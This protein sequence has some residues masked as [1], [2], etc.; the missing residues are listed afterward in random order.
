MCF[1]FFKAMGHEVGD[2]LCEVKQIDNCRHLLD[3]GNKILLPSDVTAL[4]PDGAIGRD[5]GEVRQMGRSL[6]GGWK[7]L[8][9]GSRFSR[10]V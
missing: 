5:D 4:S 1:T 10:R 8:D 6:P 7:G 3:L 2:S 9:I